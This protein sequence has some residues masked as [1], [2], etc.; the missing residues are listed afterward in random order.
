M[1]DPNTTPESRRRWEANA[2]CWDA[3]MGDLSNSFHRTIVRPHTEELLGVRPGDLVLDIAC[4]NGNFSAWL[5]EKGAEVTAFDF[6]AKMIGHAKRRRTAHPDRIGFFVCDATDYEQLMRLP[7]D[8]PFDKAVA[9]MAVMDIAAIGPLFRAVFG[10][11]KPGGVFVFSTHH[12]CFVKPDGNYLTPFV[13]EGEAIAGQPVKQLYYHRSLQEI[14]QTGFAAG[15]VVDG[16]YEVPD[17]DP[18]IPVIAIVRMRK[19]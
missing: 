16:F 17:N 15:F 14:F 3:R 12:P 7:K 6:S 19:A 2:D 4:G 8:R 11:L 18:E 13:H 9:N 5:A 10:M 1:S